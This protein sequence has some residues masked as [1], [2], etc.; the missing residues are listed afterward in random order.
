MIKEIQLSEARSSNNNNA[1]EKEQLRKF[2]KKSQVC[3]I[4]FLCVAKQSVVYKF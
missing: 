1:K 3:K 4:A 2:A